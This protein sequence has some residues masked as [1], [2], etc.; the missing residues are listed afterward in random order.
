M[1]KNITSQL[2]TFRCLEASISCSLL[3]CIAS[4][5]PLNSNVFIAKSSSRPIT[6]S[7]WQ[8][9]RAIPTHSATMA[10]LVFLARAWREKWLAK[11]FNS[12]LLQTTKAEK[13]PWFSAN[14]MRNSLPVSMM[15]LKNTPHSFVMYMLVAPSILSWRRDCLMDALRFFRNKSHA[16]KEER[17]FQNGKKESIKVFIM[18]NQSPSGLIRN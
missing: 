1:I 8:Y 5:I 13:Q 2:T 10:T 16:Y 3:Y 15:L 4:L 7:C 11:V 6:E 17:K 14:V 9:V 18:K 12:A